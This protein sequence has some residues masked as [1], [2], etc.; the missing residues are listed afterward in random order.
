MNILV[1]SN[2]Q[3]YQDP[4]SSFVHQLSDACARLGH[5]VRVVILTALGKTDCFGRKVNYPCRVDKWD[6]VELVHVSYLSL[7]NLGDGGFNKK[8]A[9]RS[10]LWNRNQVLGDFRPDIIHAH[11]LTTST[12]VGIA[13]K[14]KLGIPLVITTHGSDLMILVISSGL[15]SILSLLSPIR[16]RYS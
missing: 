4:P 10:V 6:A 5:R 7:S 13:L 11:S 12:A 2:Y 1:V 9:V 14:E 8:S 16:E 15:N 3:L